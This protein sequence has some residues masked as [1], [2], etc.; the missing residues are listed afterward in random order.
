[1]KHP[2]MESK[3]S[4]DGIPWVFVKF[5]LPLILFGINGRRN[6]I[7]TREGPSIPVVSEV[8]LPID[9]STQ[10]HQHKKKCFTLFEGTIRNV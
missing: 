6:L 8:I 5:L 2:K 4:L 10:S 3:T 7:K 1:M 9:A